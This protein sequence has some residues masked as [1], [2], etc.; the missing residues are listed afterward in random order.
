MGS[1][2]A[3]ALVDLAKSKDALEEVHADVDALTSILK[4]NETLNE[5]LLNPIITDEKKK[6]LLESL[7]KEAGFNESTKTFL[8][9]TVDKGRIDCLEEICQF[10]ES[11]YCKLTDT[12][13][14]E[15]VA[16]AFRRVLKICGFRSF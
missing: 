16:V 9:L 10:F 13:V 6:E 14:G 1:A 7:S 4:E 8:F 11:E 15:H 3:V 5:F 2:Y 12:Q